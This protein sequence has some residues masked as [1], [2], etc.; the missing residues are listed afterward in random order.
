MQ[1]RSSN[2]KTLLSKVFRLFDGR[3]ITHYAIMNLEIVSKDW[4]QA[5][6]A[7][8]YIKTKLS[9]EKECFSHIHTLNEIIFDKGN[10]TAVISI[11]RMDVLLNEIEKESK[12]NES[13]A[14][15]IDS[16]YIKRIQWWKIDPTIKQVIQ[17]PFKKLK[18]YEN[19]L[20]IQDRLFMDFYTKRQVAG[21]IKYFNDA[22]RNINNIK[23]HLTDE[24]KSL[25]NDYATIRVTL[26]EKEIKNLFKSDI[27]GK[28]SKSDINFLFN[29]YSFTRHE[30]GVLASCDT[31]SNSKGSDYWP[32][33]ISFGN[34]FGND[35]KSRQHSIFK[36][37]LL[38]HGIANMLLGSF[39]RHI[40]KLY[41]DYKDPLRDVNKLPEIFKD[42]L[43]DKLVATGVFYSKSR[44]NQEEKEAE[45][46]EKKDEKREAMSK[47]KKMLFD[48]DLTELERLSKYLVKEISSIRSYCESEGNR[49]FALEDNEILG[50]S[51]MILNKFTY[52]IL[53]DLLYMQAK[54]SRLLLLFGKLQGLFEFLFNFSIYCHCCPTSF[55]MLEE[56]NSL[57]VS[58]YFIWK[59]NLYT[60]SLK[61]KGIDADLKH[62]DYFKKGQSL[63]HQ[64]S[65]CGLKFYCEVLV[66]DGFSVKQ[67]DVYGKTPLDIAKTKQ[68][69]SIVTLLRVEYLTQST[70]II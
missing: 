64:A 5:T 20:L 28:C 49:Q 4:A 13:S 67:T 29:Y 14:A 45:E 63:L 56:S 2:K 57:C 43:L 48:N 32:F 22:N 16:T 10:K 26:F 60:D 44:N 6:N 46:K 58:E 9:H 31:L 3:G 12:E 39:D 30:C 8:E 40:H 21:N 52:V 69:L 65:E 7:W 47:C 23:A 36:F 54:K 61:E 51:H 38:Y 18:S 41:E 15:P 19:D 24:L 33:I 55:S 62:F 34:R 70:H 68:H 11:E 37:F 53:H 35:E 59:E 17:A 1:Q 50:M 42:Y 27:G 66:K 25:W